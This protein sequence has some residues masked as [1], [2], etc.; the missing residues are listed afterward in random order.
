MAGTAPASVVY[1]DDEVLCFMGI[2]PSA[3]GECM[4]IPLTHVDHFTDLDEA[5]AAKVMAVA[6]RVGRRVREA[7]EPERV[8]FVVH[9]YGVPHAHLLVVPQHGPDHVTSDRF[10]RVVGGE[11]AF[12]VEHV[13]VPPRDALN[14]D[15]ERIRAGLRG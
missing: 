5:L 10:A 14:R 12:G 6:H 7:F 11:V 1:R 15:A 9:G 13:P 3:P 4:V 2:Q 8:G